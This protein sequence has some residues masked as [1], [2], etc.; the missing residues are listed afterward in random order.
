MFFQNLNAIKRC[1]WHALAKFNFNELKHDPKANHECLKSRAQIFS[2]Y[3]T[4]Q[5][6]YFS[7]ED[8]NALNFLKLFGDFLRTSSTKFHFAHNENCTANK[9]SEYL[10]LLQ[11]VQQYQD[12]VEDLEIM[13]DMC[14]LNL[15]DHIH[16][17]FKKAEVVVLKQPKVFLSDI[18]FYFPY[19][20][21]FELSFSSV[22]NRGFIDCEFR[23]LDDLTIG[24]A[25]KKFD[26][27]FKSFLIKNSRIQHISFTSPTSRST[28]ELVKKFLRN[29]KHVS[30]FDKVVDDDA[31]NEIFL[32]GV[33]K[34]E[35]NFDNGIE[36]EPPIGITFGGDELQELSLNCDSI[37]RNYKY[38]NTLYRYPNVKSLTLGKEY[39]LLRIVGK[40]PH[41][42]RANFTNLYADDDSVLKFIEKC[43]NLEKVNF[44]FGPEVADLAQRTAWELQRTFGIESLNDPYNHL[45]FEWNNPNS[46]NSK[47]VASGLVCLLIIIHICHALLY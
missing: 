34:L 5:Q 47:F 19:I 30:I 6:F 15:F 28:F 16:Y 8:P 24:G 39:D 33:Q 21:K 37:D 27:T 32:P 40:F 11:Y 7:T 29:L 13:G 35:L 42:T 36:C 44:V 25:D 18:C 31:E 10:Q 9:K 4:S 38:F 23:L 22:D 12:S 14:G 43:D 46:S 1:N 17:A 3:H 26:E 45:R 2:R 20:R 41:L